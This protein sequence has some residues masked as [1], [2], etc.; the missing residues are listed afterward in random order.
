MIHSMTAFGTA[1]VESTQGSL[2]VEL[3]T[4][5]SRFLD[6][7]IRVADELRFLEGS[8]REL[9]GKYVKRGKVDIRISHSYVN[10]LSRDELDTDRVALLTQQLAVARQH[11]PDIPSPRLHELLKSSSEHDA[12]KLDVEVWSS[13]CTDAC[14]QALKQLQA[15]RQRE[16]SRLAQTMLDCASEMGTIIEQTEQH[17][18]ELTRLHQE[19][20]TARLRDAL[21]A[22][23]PDGLAQISGP[24]LS[25]RIAQEASLFSLR[26]DVAEELTRLR[27]HIDELRLL[28]SGTNT[29]KQPKSSTGKRLDFLCQEMNREANTLGS[30]AASMDTT[31]AAIDLKLLI[32]QLREQAQNIE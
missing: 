6:I 15:G 2:T 14:E 27:S 23:S 4:V 10:D 1:R 31:R 24:E 5:N 3:R 32:E 28:L 11:M 29:P 22:V 16:G 7:H 9:T 20:I 13:M 30:K 19:K 18:P 8:V 26:N 21:D 12:N 25:A 17:L